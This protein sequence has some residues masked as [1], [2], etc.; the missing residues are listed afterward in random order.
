MLRPPILVLLL[1]LAAAPVTAQSASDTVATARHDR[2]MR[3]IEARRVTQPGL[4]ARDA[5]DASN[6]LARASGGPSG[7]ALRTGRRLDEVATSP[8]LGGSGPLPPLIPR[9]ADIL[10]RSTM[11]A[12]PGL[13]A[14]PLHVVDQLIARARAAAAEG[15]S[16]DAAADL[17]FA[18][19][20]LGRL[21]APPAA[22]L[23]E[24]RAA[25]DALR[26]GSATPA[27]H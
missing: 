21:A 27:L 16:G 22:A 13:G 6:A 12:S 4:A 23:A 9:A 17:Q 14:D 26:I 18:E 20:Q 19:R 8:T 24:R 15:R 11:P 10:S 7:Q 2:T 3:A 1:A 25:I 5:R